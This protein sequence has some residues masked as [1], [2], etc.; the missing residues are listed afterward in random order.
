MGATLLVV[1][2]ALALG[3]GP[4]GIEVRVERARDRQVIDGFGGAL[5]YW[6]YNADEA[7]LRVAFE[8]LGA[9]IVR[10]PAEVPQAGDPDTYRAVL[11]RVSRVAPEAKV[12]L[13]FWQP[14]AQDATRPEDWLDVDAAGMYRLKP[15]RAGA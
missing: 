7:A 1:A 10:I 14:R 8:D 5:A 13:S 3:P 15:A 9:T 11:E 12:Y 6:G 2:A 4:D